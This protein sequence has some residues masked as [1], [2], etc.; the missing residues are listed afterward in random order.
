MLL[1]DLLESYRRRYLDSTELSAWA[2]KLLMEGHETDAVL[3]AAG[4]PQMNEIDT[5]RY[6][7]EILRDVGVTSDI[8]CEIE[9]VI[10][11]V[12][13]DECRRGVRPGALVLWKFDDIRRSIGFGEQ[14]I[15]HLREDSTD[16]T[17]DSGFRAAGLIGDVLEANIIECFERSAWLG[18]EKESKDR[19]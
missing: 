11:R 17:N 8:D 3:I 6:F 18:D 19:D 2:E 13:V 9:T 14:V 12:W 4:N 10:R 15:L 5:R 1:G 7:V 16:G